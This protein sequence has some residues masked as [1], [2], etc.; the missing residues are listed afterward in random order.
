MCTRVRQ[1]GNIAATGMAFTS[2]SHGNSLFLYSACIYCV[3][4]MDVE[5]MVSL[6]GKT[7]TTGL[8]V[9]MMHVHDSLQVMFILSTLS[10]LIHGL[11]M[12][13]VHVHVISR[14]LL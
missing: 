12:G 2:R 4:E 14:K 11:C 1:W 9:H 7:S 10:S 5:C 8:F 3:L 6:C 13:R